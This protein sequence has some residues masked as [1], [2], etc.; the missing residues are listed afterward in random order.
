MSSAEPLTKAAAPAALSLDADQQAAGVPVHFVTGKDGGEMDFRL[1]LTCLDGPREERWSLLGEP[2]TL[3]PTGAGLN[4]VAAGGLMLCEAAVPRSEDPRRNARDL[5]L[6]LLAYLEES[7]YTH[8]VKGWNYLEAINEGEGDTERYKQFCLGRGEALDA[9]WHQDYLPA[10]TG[11]GGGAGTGLRVSLLASRSRPEL[12]ENPR[13][14][15]AY[16]YPRQYGPKSP[17]FSRA[18]T[19]GRPEGP[20]WLLISGTAAIVGH[21]SLH[22]SSIEGQ[23]EETLR[24]WSALFDAYEAKTGKRPSL[25]DRAC[26]RVYLRN[27]EQLQT[28]RPLLQA[29]GLPLHRTIF[30]RADICRREL[31][32]EMDGTL[33]LD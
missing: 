24:N 15:S 10:G 22:V 6:R 19:I 16:R 20:N 29:A 2:V 28:V 12:V 31:L 17:S 5:Y 9:R 21:D 8:I 1:P 25:V 7:G 18:A 23:V 32:F 13:Q 14:V 26:Y 11:V 33:Q 27:G 30:L 4:A 3:P